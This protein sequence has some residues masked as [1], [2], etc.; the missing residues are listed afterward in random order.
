MFWEVGL[1]SSSGGNGVEAAPQLGPAEIALL[2]QWA[3]CVIYHLLYM[4]TDLH[5]F[6]GR[7][8]KVCNKC[9]EFHEGLKLR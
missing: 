1:Y 8:S 3:A 6:H 9:C 7:W 4:H 2:D 5:F